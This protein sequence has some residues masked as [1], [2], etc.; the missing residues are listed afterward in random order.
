M[1]SE[2]DKVLA[3]LEFSADDFY[4]ADDYHYFRPDKSI[5]GFTT[6]FGL[7][8]QRFCAVCRGEIAADFDYPLIDN[9]AVPMLKITA[10]LEDWCLYTQACSITLNDREV[11]SGEL[12]LENVSDGWPSIYFPLQND[13]L[14]ADI[15]NTL[16][17]KNLEPAKQALM[18]CSADIIVFESPAPFT[19]CYLPSRVPVFPAGAVSLYVGTDSD[20]HRHDESGEMQRILNY[21]INTGMGN[22]INFRHSPGRNYAP[23]QL[24]SKETWLGWLDKCADN[25]VAV[26]FHKLPDSLSWSEVKEHCGDLLRGSSIHEPYLVFNPLVRPEKKARFIDPQIDMSTIKD[27][28]IQYVDSEVAGAKEKDITTFCGDPSLLCVYLRDCDIDIVIAEPVSNCALLYGAARA[29]GKVFGSHIPVDW[30]LGGTH[31]SSTSLMFK[32]LLELC[33]AYGG[34]YLYTENS[35]FKTVSHFRND[36]ED[37]F[38]VENRQILR[39]FCCFAME[40]PRRGVPQKRLAAVYGN[41]E[42]MFWLP[43]DRI[44]E[45]VDTNDWDQKIWG[46]WEDTSYQMVWKAVEAWLPVFSCRRMEQDETLTR[47]FSGTPFGPVDVVSPYSDLSAYRIISFFGWN[48]MDEKIYEN[49]LSYVEQGGILL[50]CACHFDTRV[51][52][53]EPVKLFRDGKISELAGC[54]I[55]GSTSSGYGNIRACLLEN[56][57]AVQIDDNL[58]VHKRGNGKVYFYSFLDIPAESRLIRKIKATLKQITE[59]SRDEDE[60]IISGDD[61]PYINYNVWKQSD[62]SCTVYFSNVDWDND[63]PKNIKIKYR[64]RT[65]SLQLGKAETVAM[66]LK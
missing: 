52:P 66:Q 11:F 64:G 22:F 61:S 17:I 38:C 55:N 41:L 47:M 58:Y 6:A 43:D 2:Y 48:T 35:L 24:A 14:N 54:D 13:C 51:D 50:I 57:S 53:A 5:H 49:L 56:L 44:P 63:C 7:D 32:L 8:Q 33:Y 15:P 19:D 3:H 1:E 21:F 45:L 46:R 40:H 12:F 25:G 62:G 31:D 20:D 16:T 60:I 34:E 18:L 65:T 42:S 26:A 36:W 30:Y 39:E 27:S 28:Y 9:D 59:E 23:G 10:M 29:S 37:E 4:N